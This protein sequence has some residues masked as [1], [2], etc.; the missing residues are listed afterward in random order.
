MVEDSKEG[1]KLAKCEEN[2]APHLAHFE[3]EDSSDDDETSS[4]GSSLVSLRVS[5]DFDQVPALPLQ[6]Q[7]DNAGA[8]SFLNEA[9]SF[10]P[11]ET[12]QCS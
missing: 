6:D 10:A 4:L 7:Q 3:N 11:S 8:D 1:Q 12:T 2:N 9:P 5:D